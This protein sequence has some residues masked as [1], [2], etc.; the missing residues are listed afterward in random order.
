MAIKGIAH[1]YRE[2]KRHVITSQTDH[3]CVLDSCRHL[4]QEGFEVTYLPV[5]PNGLV[6]LKQLEARTAAPAPALSD[7]AP[8]AAMREDTAVVSIMAV[9][10]EI[11]VMQ[12]LAEIGAL[13]RARGIFF[14]TDAAQ[15][16]GKMPLDVNAMKID[17]MSISGHKASA[18]V[19]VQTRPATHAS[20]AD[21][22]PKGR[23]RHLLASPP[24]RAPGPAHQWGRPGARP[25][26]R[27]RTHP[28][29]CG[30][31]RRL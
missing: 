25:A 18:C 31:G 2:R 11:G 4:E 13:C 29:R 28:P 12:P 6:D 30:P 15:A 21:L 17:A 3:K 5:Q 24:A 19:R 8:Q 26:Q 20:S 9:N 16:V 23:G 22:R 14:H 10:N 27:H 7:A 1:F